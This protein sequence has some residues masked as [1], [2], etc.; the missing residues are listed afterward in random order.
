MIRS[1]RMILCMVLFI[2]IAVPSLHAQIVFDGSP[3]TA[4]PPATLGPYTM[5]TFPADPRPD[6]T[7]LTTVTG[8]NGDVIFD[9][10]MLR[11]TPGVSW[12]PGWSHGYTGPIYYRGGNDVTM[13]M[14]ANT[15]AFYFYAEPN[16][17]S[18]FT[19]TATAQDNTSSGPI[20]VAGAGGAKYFGFYSTNG[21]PLVSIAVSVSGSPSGF[22]VGEFGI[23]QCAAPTIAVTVTPAMLWPPNHTMATINATVAVTADCGGDVITLESVTSNEPDNGPE[24]GNTIND[25]QGVSTGTADYEFMVRKERSG[26]GTGREY[27]ATY[28][29]TD[30]AGNTATASAVVSV[31]LSLAKNGADVSVV[32]GIIELEQNYPNPFNP[33]TTINYVVP[34]AGRV[35]LAIFDMMGREIAMLVNEE[36]ESG[37][38]S[39]SFDASHL[40]SGN[41]ISRLSMGDQSVIRTMTLSK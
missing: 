22:A 19:F 5:M 32:P 8:P 12:N 26:I 7:N 13:T 31:P 23:Y 10:N 33:S 3:G 9:Q 6:F 20:S 39:V 40:P 4:A 29:V 35:T 36:Q 15:V 25:I 37:R 28:M 41:Y 17:H 30:G 38:Y 1:T 14:P 21:V 24:D 18:T 11:A 16:I 34:E 2:T 27:T